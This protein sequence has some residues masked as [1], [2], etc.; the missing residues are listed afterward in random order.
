MVEATYVTDPLPIVVTEIMFNP[1]EDPQGLHSTNDF[2]FIE[3]QNIGTE[4][5]DVRGVR[6]VG[7]RIEAELGGGEVTLLQPGGYAVAVHD[8]EAFASRYGSDGVFVAGVIEGVLSNNRMELTLIGSLDEPLLVFTYEDW[9]P[10]T[11]GAGR[12]LVIRDPHADRSTWNLQESWA[13][14]AEVHGSPGRADTGGPAGGLQIP[15]DFVQDAS[16]NIADAV[17]VLRYLFSGGGNAP[18][19]SEAGTTA[20]L[21]ADG[22]ANLTVSDAVH[23][24]NFLFLG[25]T[26]HALGISCMRIEGCAD[27]CS[28]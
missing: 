21:D 8:R 26:P 12:S 25:G 1:A 5:V 23:T 27:V 4:P 11:D 15:G 9:Y 14:S 3:I 17:G 22:D 16:L 7:P 10:E 20:L 13:P 28:Q 19:A 6:V 18:C 24:L 2:E